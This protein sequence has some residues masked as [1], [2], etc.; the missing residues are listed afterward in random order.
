MLQNRF[1]MKQIKSR[2]LIF[3]FI[4]SFYI[5]LNSQTNSDGTS[6]QFLFPDFYMS[7]VRMKNGQSQSVNLNYNTISEKMVYEK[8]GKLYDMVNSMM[9][10]TVF[11]QN[12]KFVPVGNVFYEVL[13]VAPVSLFVQYK[14][15][16]LSPGAPAGYGGTSQVSNTKMMTSVDLS[17]GHYNLKLP[18]DFKVKVDAIYWIRK[19]ND[20]YSFV[21]ERQFLKI[22]PDKESQFKQFIKQNRIRID[23]LPDLV[24]LIEYCNELMR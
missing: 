10:D 11:L 6:P 7:K 14:G 4:I 20:T 13:L 9:V 16:L 12:C 19:G 24:K 3:L 18:A 17:S 5:P 22:F 8:E 15:E 23:K 21:N 2:I 1:N